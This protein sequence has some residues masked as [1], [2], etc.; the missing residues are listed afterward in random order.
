MLFA[1]YF[2]DV[3]DVSQEIRGG[4]TLYGITE[5]IE[6]GAPRRF[7]VMTDAQSSCMN[8]TAALY[9]IVELAVGDEDIHDS[10][11]VS[12][13]RIGKDVAVTLRS[14]GWKR[15]KGTLFRLIFKDAKIILEHAPVNRFLQGL[16]QSTGE[17]GTKT[18]YFS[19]D[20]DEACLQVEA[21]MLVIMDS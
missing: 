1:V 19:A 4:E 18:Y 20:D 6:P 14:D 10:Q 21:G 16:S 3:S 8:L 2:H 15:P 11:L 17:A 5:T 13:E 12:I 9:S 7:H